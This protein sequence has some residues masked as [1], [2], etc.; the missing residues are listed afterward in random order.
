MDIDAGQE[1]DVVS[2]I[3][4]RRLLCLYLKRHRVMTIGEMI[5]ALRADGYGVVGRASKV[6][7]DALRWEVP[8]GRVKR[9]RRG[10][11]GFG[12]VPRSTEYRMRKGLERMAWW[13]RCV[14]ADREG[15]ERPAAPP[16]WG[17][18]YRIEHDRS[19]VAPGPLRLVSLND[20]P[21]IKALGFV[22]DESWLL[23]MGLDVA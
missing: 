14:R 18:R 1:L 11:Y 15:V 7:S 16:M 5:E 23:N 8:W 13:H 3:D 19:F 2:G 9:L 21:E 12:R 4:L 22:Y 20:L 10:V 17:L 6:I